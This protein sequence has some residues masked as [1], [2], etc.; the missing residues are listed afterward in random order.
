MLRKAPIIA[1]LLAAV[2][3]LPALAGTTA[4]EPPPMSFSFDGVFGR[5]DQAQLQRGYRV[6]REV[7][8]AC[9]SM[10]F[11]T[12]RN[13]GQPGG[14]FWDPHYP[15]PND[16]PVVKAIAREYQVPDIDPDTGDPNRRPGTPADA[17]VRPYA[18]DAAAAAS[19]GGAVPPDLSM[20]ASAREGGAPYIASLLAGYETPPTG[21]TMT[22]NQHYNPF[23]HGDLTS[24]WTGRGHA[25]EGGFI[26]MPAP[27]HGVG[28]VSYDDGTPSNVQTNARDVAAFLQWAADPH[29]EARKQTGLA[30]IIFLLIFTGLLYASYR[31]IWAGVAH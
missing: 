10:N 4:R 9:H 15:N 6:Y 24:Y 11:L 7:C 3:A 30:V 23:M 27:L 31:R 2:F 26:A 1:A 29:M 14:P 19:N 13:L 22:A 28:Q 25:P 12:F 17:F 8:S 18:N 20:M 21:L 5:Y 16:N